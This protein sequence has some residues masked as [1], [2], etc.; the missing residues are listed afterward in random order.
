[1]L[2]LIAGRLLSSVASAFSFVFQTRAI[3]VS[4]KKKGKEIASPLTL[5]FFSVCCMFY[6][7]KD[8]SYLW[9]VNLLCIFNWNF[10]CCASYRNLPWCA[11]DC[12]GSCEIVSSPVTTVNY[13]NT[14]KKKNN[15]MK[16]KINTT[17]KR[18]IRNSFVPRSFA[19]RGRKNAHHPGNI[20]I[21]KL[22]AMSW[23]R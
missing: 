2:N 19:W 14:H 23:L 7:I 18:K 20:Y 8:Q 1:M 3:E 6:H 13:F 12:C 9:D 21:K 16:I 10:F 15:N 22:V 11:K 5:S 4:G 17:L